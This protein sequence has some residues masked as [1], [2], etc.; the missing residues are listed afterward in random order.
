MPTLV[1]ARETG[2][3][4]TA[5]DLHQPFLDEL[6][7]RAEHGGLADRITPV[8]ASMDALDFPD[9]SF[10]LIWSEGAIYV[11]GFA[12]GLRA[13]KRLLKPTGAIAVTELTW[14][15][16]SIPAEAARFWSEHHPAM[17]D[18]DTN[19]ATIESAGFA[20]IEHFVLP[21]A[22]W[23]DQYYAP[24]EQRIDALRRG[25]RD[26]R[27]AMTFLD[28]AQREIA[29]YRTCSA[30]YGYVFYVARNIG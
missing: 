14:L 19:L 6:I 12:E 29:L 20:S 10:D 23:W 7:R 21:E 13:W 5:I 30:S 16:R 25:Y 1:L 22:A 26:D 3:Y 27:Q 17:S 28:G 2:G 15:D 11:M 8:R 24:L 9:A 18:V 4:V